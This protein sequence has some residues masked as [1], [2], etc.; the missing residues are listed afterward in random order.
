[1]EPEPRSSSTSGLS[2]LSDET[3]L[4]LVSA[5]DELALAELYDRFGGV[6]YRLAL[7]V[8]R[9]PNL[10]EDAVQDGFVTVWRSAGRF[11]R[12]RANAKAWIL[13]LVHRRAVDLV[14]REQVRRSHSQPLDLASTPEEDPRRVEARVAE[15]DAMRTA[16][17]QL[18]DTEREAI[19]LAYY[20]GLTQRQIAERLH[21]PLGT[22]KSRTFQGLAHLR[23]LLAD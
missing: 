16:L 5:R 18:P 2:R 13:M 11:L 7:R 23:V 3:L 14:R 12:Q 10:A 6:A 19:Q 20:G 9:D 17:E 8:V 15:R 1:M 21:C 4:G 22:V